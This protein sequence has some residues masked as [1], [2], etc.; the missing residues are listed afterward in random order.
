[1]Y[2]REKAGVGVSVSTVIPGAVRSRRNS[3][4][5]I[6]SQLKARYYAASEELHVIYRLDQYMTAGIE[7]SVSLISAFLPVFTYKMAAKTNWHRYG[8]IITSLSLKTFLFCKSFP[9]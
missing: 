3:K 1:V 9:P 4:D 5:V 7:L 8:T 2:R 6:W